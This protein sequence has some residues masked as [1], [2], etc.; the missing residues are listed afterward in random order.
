[1]YTHILDRVWANNILCYQLLDF[2]LGLRELS[3]LS[4]PIIRLAMD[5]Y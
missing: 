2:N 3:N 1:M 5:G 4:I